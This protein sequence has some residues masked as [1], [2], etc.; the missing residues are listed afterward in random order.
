MTVTTR[1]QPEQLTALN[2]AAPA[3]IQY[4]PAIEAEIAVLGRNIARIPLLSARYPARWLAIQL[5]EGDAALRQE[6]LS[7][8]AGDVMGAALAES[9]NRLRQHYGDDIDIA[10]AD[11]RYQFANQV[12]RTV[13]K[14]AAGQ[15]MTRSDKVDRLATHPVFGAPIFLMVMWAMFKIT[16]DVA[17]PYIGWVENVISGPVTHLLLLLLRGLGLSDTWL[18]SLLLDGIVAG[19]GGVL[20][21]VPVLTMLYFVLALLEDSG[22]M[23]R[24]AFVMDRL[25]NVLGLHGKSFMPMIVGFGCS[26]P[27]IYATRTLENKRD[28]LLTGLLVP[29]MS[30]GARLPVYILFATIFFPNHIGAVVFGLYITGVLVAI[31]FGFVLKKTLFKGEESLPFVMELPPYQLPTLKNIRIQVWARTAAFI[32]N[33]ATV[34]LM[35][36]VVIWLLT[37]IPLAGR[38][39]FAKVSMPDS[40]FAGVARVLTPV[41]KPLGFGSWETG[42]ALLTGLVAKEVVIST[43]SQVYA[44]EDTGLAGVPENHSVGQDLVAVGTGFVSATVDTVKSMP[45]LL[46]I[47]LFPEDKTHFSTALIASTQTAFEQTS[48]GHATLAAL[49]FMVFVLLYTPCVATIAAER[50]EF[51]VKWMWFS[52]AGQVGIAWLGALVVFQGGLLLGLG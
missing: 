50:H 15:A 38:G 10:L 26:V 30:C 52:I 36:S 7:A 42:G 5:L 18:Q 32:R 51:G 28:R 16:T 43:L 35:A 25:M 34:I 9:L 46:G 8:P 23:A 47:N 29:F 19:V 44:P 2:A 41:L 17:T 11:R 6:A 37:A 39:T 3:V 12:T 24:A 45:L 22:Y 20:V 1:L 27:A 14:T 21:F 49:A 4:G 31:A 33:A 40:A 48:N 13:V